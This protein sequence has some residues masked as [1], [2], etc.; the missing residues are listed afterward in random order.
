MDRSSTL[1]S[2]NDNSY[3]TWKIQMKMFLMK[4][5]LFSIVDGSEEAPG[6]TVA[7]AQQKFATRRDRAM[8]NIV[9]H[10]EPKLIY[11]IGDPTDPAVV[12][13]KLKDTFQKKSW[14]NKLRLRK[15]LYKMELKPQDDLRSHFKEFVELFDAMAVIGDP[16]E[17]EDKVINLLASLPDNYGTM[18]TAL[19]ALE[20]VPTWETVTERLLHEETKFKSSCDADESKAFMSKR[21][22]KSSNLTCFECQK[23]D[24]V[25]KN[26]HAYKERMRKY[27]NQPKK[28]GKSRA[29]LHQSKNESDS[30]EIT[31]IATSFTDSALI[32]S[33][34]QSGSWILDSGSTHH[35]CYERKLFKNLQDCNDGTKITVGDGTAIS[36]EGRGEV[37]VKL[38][39]PSNKTIKCTLKNVLY[40]PK[41][42]S[43]LV[44]IAQ[45]SSDRKSVEF[46]TDS[47]K[48]LDQKKKMIA[49][50]KRIGNL[51]L[52]D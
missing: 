42:S 44:S 21:S 11:L 6:G 12:W 48:I 13:T 47:C 46:F 29:N 23:T 18:V 17:E 19:E 43:N 4:D 1:V 7:D 32:G 5:G 27:H 9:L 36:V 8:A 14:S 26:C 30:D 25:R 35:M 2:L 3:A 50:G 15:K 28:S 31:L 41:L 22:Y 37:E 38:N 16:V 40:V 52:L 45:I 24:H 49:H 34:V 51:Y 39:L 20:N 33:V 10:I